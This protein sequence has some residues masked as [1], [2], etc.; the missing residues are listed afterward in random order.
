MPEGVRNIADREG[1]ERATSRAISELLTRVGAVEGRLVAVS[2]EVESTRLLI[3]EYREAVDRIL[4]SVR[5]QTGRS[6]AAA[7]RVR[8]VQAELEE[9]VLAVRKA[10]IANGPM[11]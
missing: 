10:L 5:A 1:D 3:N 2:H 4:H 9:Q 6:V 8:K 7:E 11:T